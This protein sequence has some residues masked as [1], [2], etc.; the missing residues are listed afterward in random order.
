MNNKDVEDPLRSLDDVFEPDSR[1]TLFI[2]NL[3]AIHAEL[4]TIE[5]HRSV[6]VD[7]RQLFETAKNLTLYS[8]FVYRF[9]QVA[10]L[11]SFS[12]LEMALRERYKIEH[13]DKKVPTLQRLL[14]HAKIKNWISDEKFPSRYRKAKLFAEHGNTMKIM[15]NVD[16][17][18]GEAIRFGAPTEEDINLALKEMD[19]VEGFTSSAAKLRNTLAHGSKMLHPNSIST[20]RTNSEVINQLFE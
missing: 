17:K 20:L 16:L 18:K 15:K 14:N 6:P 3:Q 13:P 4:S 7:V 1:H 11:I 5:L 8:W 9:H 12:A 19:L 10:E 2:C